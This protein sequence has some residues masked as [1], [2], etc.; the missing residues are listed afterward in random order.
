MAA[1]DAVSIA[2]SDQSAGQAA[3]QV[4]ISLRAS[5][6]EGLMRLDLFNVDPGFWYYQE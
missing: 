3:I 4:A 2:V 1:L 5:E 6:G